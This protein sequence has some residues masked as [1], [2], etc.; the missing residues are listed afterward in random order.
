M[1]I[2]QRGIGQIIAVGLLFIRRRLSD[3]DPPAG[4]RPNHQPKEE[5]HA[6][7]SAQAGQGGVNCG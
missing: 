3:E 6:W 1:R 7:L 2:R 4:D 5:R